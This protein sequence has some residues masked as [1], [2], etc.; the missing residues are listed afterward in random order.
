VGGLDT[1]PVRRSVYFHMA[2]R[3]QCWPC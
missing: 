1:L 2:L 3:A